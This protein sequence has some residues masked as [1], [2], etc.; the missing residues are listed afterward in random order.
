M[1]N[2][3]LSHFMSPLLLKTEL[4]DGLAWKTVYFQP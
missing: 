2:R 1:E 3:A 4:Q